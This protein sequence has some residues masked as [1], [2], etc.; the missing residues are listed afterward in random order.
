MSCVPTQFVKVILAIV[1]LACLLFTVSTSAQSDPVTDSQDHQISIS[2]LFSDGNMIG[3]LG[4]YRT[5]MQENPDLQGRIS[6]QFL[7][8]SFFNEA[9]PAVLAN[10]DVLVLDMMNQAMLDRFNE[11]HGI[12]LIDSIT[13]QGKVVA[14][15]IGVQP[16]EY[17]TEQGAVWDKTALAYW[18]NGGPQN[19]L[20]L[21]K[22]S[23]QQAGI[24]GLTIPP[25]QPGLKFGYYYPSRDFSEHTSEHPPEHSSRSGGQAFASW[26]E[27]AD[28]MHSKDLLQKGKPRVAVGFYKSTFYGSE[29]EVVD[30]VIA[31]IERSGAVAIPF[32]GYPGHVAFE[33]MLIDKNGGSRA[34]VGLSFL[35]RFANF[36]SSK[37]LA[38]INIPILNLATLYGRSE[39]EWR[40]SATG[41][42][43]FEGTFQVAVPELAGLIAP[44]VVGSRERQYDAAANISIV[45][46]KP[47]MPRVAMAV[48][49]ALHYARLAKKP[50]QDRRIALMYYNYPAGQANIGASYLNV[51]ES[52]ENTLKAMRKSGYDL[53]NTDLSAAS[54]LSDI[55]ARGRNIGSY[56]P[57]D[58]E[59]MLRKNS[60]AEVTMGTYNEWLGDF[61]PLLSKKILKDWGSP[62]QEKLMT[63][64]FDD[65]K[66]FIIPRLEYGNIILLPQPVRGWSEDLEKLYHAD[67]LAPHHQ[68]VAVYSWLRKT[69]DIDAIVHMGTH[70]TLE[71]LDGKASGLSREDAPDAL[72]GDIP[73][74]NIYNV[75]VVG[76]GLVARRRGMA[77]LVDHMVPPFIAS[78]LYSD[79]A[80]LNETINDYHNNLHKNAALAAIYARQIIEQLQ[81]TGI[82]KS[83][84]IEATLDANGELDHDILHE[85]EEH[86]IELRA[87]FIPYGLHTFGKLP[88]EKMRR[89]TVEAITSID[90][91]QLPEFKLYN[92]QQIDKSI[93]ESASREID[94]LLNSL[95]GGFVAAGSGGEP[96]RNPDAYPTGKNFYG[97]DPSKVP[98]KAA[99]ELGVKLADQMLSNHLAE[100]G[101]Y[102]QKISFVIWG[103]E[104][105]R[106]EGILESQIF[107]LL[108]TKPIWDGRDKVVGVEV[109]PSRELGRPR[110]DILIASAAEGM[111]NNVTV[112]MD[113][114]VQKVKALEETENFVRDHYLATK[115]ALIALGYSEQDADKR[116]GVRIFDEPPGIHN[117][118]TSNIAAASGT[119]D[120]DIGMANDYINKMGH[121]FGNGFWGEP[122]QDVFKLALGGVDKVVHSSSTMLY[123]ALDND[124]FFMYMGGLAA[125][126]KKVDGNAPELV[127]TNTRNP[128]KPE[129]SSIEKFIGM[130]FNTRY[131]NPN[132]IKGMQK[133]GYA[134]ARNMVEF[135]EYMWGW[136]ATVSD[137]I[138]DNMWQQSFAVYVQDKHELGMEEFF[139]DNSPYAFQDMSVRML[140]TIRK[141]YW[142]ANQET[143]NELLSAYV[144]SVKKHGINCTEVSCGNPR[145]MEYVLLEGQKSGL[146]GVDLS[147]FRQAV[148]TAI[149]ASI[150]TLARSAEEFA[151]NND[152]R[153]AELYETAATLEGFAMEPIEQPQALPQQNDLSA[154]TNNAIAYFFQGLVVVLLL[155]WWYRR[156]MS[157]ATPD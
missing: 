107:Y 118:N 96:I 42:S 146:S 3:T 115:S 78:D 148:E 103:D 80:A 83:L 55:I 129:M 120:S 90:R 10:S 88:G 100:H 15:G 45:V 9:D 76:E 67:D 61:D 52:L 84:E 134:G 39:Q 94:S 133:E 86:M 40:E 110:I 18:Q 63:Y 151:T 30:A 16:I 147:E 24:V 27:F 11:A 49:R 114:A 136:D 144:E 72:L 19:Q 125:A 17:F 38:N 121:G 23:L 153:I 137:I 140:E 89:A 124:D 21:M 106:H 93:I 41:L 109:I 152:A 117:L 62:D 91:S 155:F 25:P 156:R 2:Y 22:F 112:L 4:A 154:A 46:D 70:G 54:I 37:L 35:M 108:G 51:A 5:L 32:F 139:D 14:V 64:Q 82:A 102:P 132:W 58:L 66:A 43:M 44:T 79:L 99:W 97:I 31:E 26:N 138:D 142:Q 98:K 8:E 143:L 127:V 57:G 65:H 13:E 28:W 6:L 48:K 69:V 122:M 71:W 74:I 20:S 47:I 95:S 149:Q 113:Q 75:D 33:R 50:V 130:E 59:E 53:G 1:S 104:T 77:T 135:V 12:D 68:Y 29:T 92:A 141:E 126:V 111:F 105:M 87:Q 116:A 123:G 81:S 36:D 73:N 145:L 60:F 157:H 34:D 56:A 128:S 150:E 131:V 101:E 85:V 7:T 119:W